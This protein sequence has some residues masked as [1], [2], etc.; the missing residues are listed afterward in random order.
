MS[1]GPDWDYI[2]LAVRVPQWYP[3]LVYAILLCVFWFLPQYI[4]WLLSKAFRAVYQWFEDIGS[5]YLTAPFTAFDTAF[6][7]K[8]GEDA[9]E[10]LRA[11]KND[12]EGMSS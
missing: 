11:K 2:K 1:K 10:R 6:K 3:T 8:Y 9:R 5:E 12:E 7:K 4:F